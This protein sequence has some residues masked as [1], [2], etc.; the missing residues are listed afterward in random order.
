MHFTSAASNDTKYQRNLDGSLILKKQNI[1]F[2]VC[3]LDVR[4]VVVQTERYINVVVFH[5][6]FLGM[7]ATHVTAVHILHTRQQQQV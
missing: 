3:S 4:C 7:R 2:T 6:Y 1:H 5:R